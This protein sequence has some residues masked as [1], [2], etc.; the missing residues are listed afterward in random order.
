MCKQSMTKMILCIHPAY[1]E[2][3]IELL[4]PRPFANRKDDMDK[5]L[6]ENRKR[7]ESSAPPPLEELGPAGAPAPA[8]TRVDETRL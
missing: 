8:A 1:R 5:W 4:G 6:D 3:M 2:D 7:G